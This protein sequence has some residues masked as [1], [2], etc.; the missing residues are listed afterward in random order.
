MFCPSQRVTPSMARSRSRYLRPVPH[1]RE[2]LLNARSS[3]ARHLKRDD[4]ALA[5]LRS[6][7]EPSLDQRGTLEHAEQAPTAAALILR[8]DL[9]GVEAGAVVAN[10]RHQPLRRLANLDPAVLCPSVLEH[11]IDGLLHDG[12]DSQ[13]D[14]VRQALRIF[15]IQVHAWA[16]ARLE[17]LEEVVKRGDQ[18]AGLGV[19]HERPEVEEEVAHLP[20][21]ALRQLAD[22]TQ[23][24]RQPL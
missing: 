7:L 1:S 8:A 2:T 10:R 21:S 18:S 13:L 24:L 17:A 16:A 11:V 12:E 19:E 9:L 15:S 5:R 23:L 6:D 14:I 20:R 4:R 3:R 22:D